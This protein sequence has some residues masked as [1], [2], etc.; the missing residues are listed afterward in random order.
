MANKDDGGPAFPIC[1]GQHGP[2]AQKFV[3][4]IAAKDWDINCCWEWAA[5]RTAK[6]YGIFSYAKKGQVRAHRF[7]FKLYT[8]REPGDMVLH[9][10][11]NPSCVNPLHL[12]EGS[13][14]ENMRQMSERKRA[15]REERHHKAKL[16]FNEV[17]AVILLHRTGEYPTRELAGIFG[18][19]QPTVAAIVKGNLWPDAYSMADAMLRARSNGEG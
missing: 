4:R 15:A 19:S 5:A 13:H 8:G 18:V 7:A 11:D 14:G 10:C 2:L 1:P 16:V 12:T 9:S 17:L 3:S 6:G